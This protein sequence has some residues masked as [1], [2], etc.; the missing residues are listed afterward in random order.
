[1]DHTY[2]TRIGLVKIGVFV[3]PDFYST[4]SSV[5]ITGDF[6]L[7]QTGGKQHEK[8]LAIMD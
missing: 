7:D 1:M 3:R 2:P 4:Y 6:Y 8:D 5:A